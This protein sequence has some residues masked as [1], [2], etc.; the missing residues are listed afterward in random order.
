MLVDVEHE[1]M[2]LA[3]EGLIELEWVIVGGFGLVLQ[4]RDGP[5][6]GVLLLGFGEA[7]YCCYY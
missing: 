4:W 5:G 3:F 2:T 6:I 1:I 7:C